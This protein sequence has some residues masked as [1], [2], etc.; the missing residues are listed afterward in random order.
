MLEWSGR[1]SWGR[2]DRSRSGRKGSVGEKVVLERRGLGRE[3]DPG[4]S[5]EFREPTAR[6]GPVSELLQ[7]E[8]RGPWK[9]QLTSKVSGTIYKHSLQY[10]IWGLIVKHRRGDACNSGT[11]TCSFLICLRKEVMWIKMPLIGNNKRRLQ[12][13]LSWCLEK[14]CHP[15][16]MYKWVM[17]RF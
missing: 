13:F 16:E 4:S 10:L 3:N 9:G 6:S 11:V 7:L 2:R 15:W 8:Q 5:M 12:I 17:L 14:K 1:V